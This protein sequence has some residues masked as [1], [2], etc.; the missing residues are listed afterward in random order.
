MTLPVVPDGYKHEYV[1]PN[2]ASPMAPGGG[3]EIVVVARET[4]TAAID[5]QVRDLLAVSIFL[6]NRRAETLRRFGD[7]ALCFQARLELS[8]AA[9]FERRDDRASYDTQDADARLADLH[10]ADV[11]SYAVGHNTSGDWAEPDER[12]E[13]TTV[14]H[15]SA[16]FA[17]R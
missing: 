1:V 7:V 4:R 10:Y 16:P 2:S 3:L 12:G 13:V 5:G 14:F 17:G 6:V 8:Y 11:C 15:E 9:G